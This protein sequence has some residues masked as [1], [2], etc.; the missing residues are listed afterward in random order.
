MAVKR[1]RKKDTNRV[2]RFCIS[3][4]VVVFV[5]VMS[6]Q[7]I[8]VYKMDQEYIARQTQLEKELADEVERGKELAEFENYTKSQEYIEDIA[9]SKLGL[10]YDNEIIFKEIK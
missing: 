5:S 7:I 1:Q 6:I 4:I 3:M 10:A 8:R 9:K 2:G